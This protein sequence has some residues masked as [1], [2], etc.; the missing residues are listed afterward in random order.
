VA[1]KRTRSARIRVELNFSAYPIRAS[2]GPLGRKWALLVL[3]N[4]ALGRARRYNELLRST[5]GMNKRILSI[6]LRELEADGFIVRAEQ[7]RSYTRWQLTQE[8]ADVLPVL[9][10]L[11]R[12]GSKRHE[13]TA[14]SGAP[15]DRLGNDFKVTYRVVSRRTKSTS[16]RR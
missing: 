6:R 9:L 4:I 12:F 1:A 11:I 5:P 7:T 3:M 2:L 10:A 16:T 13:A 14:P 8:G 15:N